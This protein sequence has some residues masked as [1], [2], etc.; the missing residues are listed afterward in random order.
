MTVS[1]SW[2]ERREIWEKQGDDSRNPY[3]IDYSRIVH[4]SSFRRLQGKTQILNLGDSDFYRTRLTHS[5]EVAQ[6]ALGIVRELR[7]KFPNH[8]ICKYLPDEFLTQAVCLTHDLGHPPFGHGGEVALNYCMRGN[9]GF[10]ANGQSL[11][12][13][14]KL[15]KFSA[16]AGSNLARRTML[17]ILKYPSSYSDVCNP[18]L[19]PSLKDKTSIF[20][21]IDREKSKPPKCY[22]D[23]ERDVAEW[24]LKPLTQNDREAFSVVDERAGSH[25][26]S[27][28]KSLDCSIMDVADDIAYGIHDL[29]DVIA[30]RL[31]RRE[32]FEA[33]VSEADCAKLI[34]D[35][36]A[37]YPDE[38]ST[39][40]YRA[41]V[42]KL[43]SDDGG[44]RKRQI[45]RIV[46]HMLVAINPFVADV[47]DEPILRFRIRLHAEEE[48][49]LGKLKGFVF[50]TVVKSPSVQHLEF[51]GQQMVVAVFDAL[52]SDP[53]SFLPKVTYE[54]FTKSDGNSRI[55]CD[56]I[57]GM[58]DAFLLRTYERLY[59]PRM[60]SVFDR[61]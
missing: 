47:F 39:D 19:K 43:F 42:E 60:G 57:A 9:G 17:G 6:L 45:S 13:L 36:A 20:G 53:K 31:V 56:H 44:T 55:I 52:N 48:A 24:L 46:H 5:L 3:E 16:H 26:R 1:D 50:K 28:H 37:R 14:S 35:L 49:L 61:L 2:A 58:T 7:Q 30:L 38:F 15:E 22:L 23:T 18:N 21:I 25:Q 51:K 27:V 8:P 34:E 10:E 12:I 33:N 32:D 59:S 4:S 41:F 11:R 54:L 29:E 40:G